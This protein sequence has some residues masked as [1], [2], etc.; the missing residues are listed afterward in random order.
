MKIALIPAR[1]GSKRVP[2][3]NIRVFAGRPMIAHSIE[4]ALAS[5]LFD[6]VV[7]STDD[8]RIADVARAAGAE[9]PF[10]RPSELAGD[11][12]GT[13]PVVRHAVEWLEHAGVTADAVCCI[14]A[15]APFIQAEDLRRGGELLAEGRWQFVFAATE[16][17]FPVFRAFRCEADGAVRMLFPEHY[18]TRS[19]DLPEV[20]HDAAQFYW[21][22]KRA[23]TEE[24]QFFGPQS[25]V[26]RI[27]RWRVQ[28]I[29]TEDDWRRA[30]AMAEYLRR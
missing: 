1:G 9:V 3:K 16:Y 2:G 7:V 24:F 25:T 14:Q 8:P 12:V 27:P 15:T 5:A 10:I 26:V 4:A 30:E 19:Q 28:D 22:T 23:W 29:D 17:A 13:A 11:H 6:R 21:G 18:G 20:L